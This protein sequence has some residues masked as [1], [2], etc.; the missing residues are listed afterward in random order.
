LSARCNSKLK[1]HL[2]TE[3]AHLRF[4]A[5]KQA[6]T[7]FHRSAIDHPHFKTYELLGQCY[8]RLKR[9]TEAIPYL[10]AATTLNCGV[11]APSLLAEVWLT[12]GH[13]TEAVVAA[14]IALSRDPRNK[15]A[16]RVREVVGSKVEGIK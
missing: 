5:T 9:L 10:A 6:A 4:S 16:L 12:L 1:S 7:L 3:V 2:T 8:M 11:R 14:N 15:A 13:H